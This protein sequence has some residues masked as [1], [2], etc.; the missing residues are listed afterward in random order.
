MACLSVERAG[1]GSSLG[2]SC[3][4]TMAAI[5]VCSELSKLPQSQRSTKE[6]GVVQVV[7]GAQG[8][9][10]CPAAALGLFGAVWLE[11]EVG[12]QVRKSAD[13]PAR[14]GGAEEKENRSNGGVGGRS[15]PCCDR[16]LRERVPRLRV[17]STYAVPRCDSDDS[18]RPPDPKAIAE[19]F[20]HKASHGSLQGSKRS[21][22]HHYHRRYGFGRQ[23]SRKTPPNLHHSRLCL[24]EA[25]SAFRISTHTP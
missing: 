9:C 22:R 20:P 2:A 6:R 3:V 1:E 14:E 18:G 5:R 15:H 23:L 7:P 10:A 25:A 24:L 17:L 12:E 16:G 4:G 8:W 13:S 19:G 11:K 21:Y